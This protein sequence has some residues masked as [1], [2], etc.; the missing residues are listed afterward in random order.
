MT[1]PQNLIGVPIDDCDL[2]SRPTQGGPYW[3]RNVNGRY[4]VVYVSADGQWVMKFSGENVNI[5]ACRGRF[6]GPLQPTKYCC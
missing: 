4:E 5:A 1:V 2:R 6:Y 3:Y